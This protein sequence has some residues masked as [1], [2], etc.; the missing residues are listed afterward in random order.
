MIQSLSALLR[1]SAMSHLGRNGIAGLSGSDWLQFLD[2]VMGRK[3]FEGEYGVLLAEATWRPELDVTPTQAEALL[4]LTREWLK[5]L[6]RYQGK[7]P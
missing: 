6:P 5:Q 3:H 2:S 7:R 4:R 1:R